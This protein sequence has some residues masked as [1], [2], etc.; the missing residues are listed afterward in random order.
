[1]LGNR[2]RGERVVRSRIIAVYSDG[3]RKIETFAVSFLDGRFENLDVPPLFVHEDTDFEDGGYLTR[4]EF[5]RLVANG[6]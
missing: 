3:M 5:G 6:N 2:N 4:E 1:M